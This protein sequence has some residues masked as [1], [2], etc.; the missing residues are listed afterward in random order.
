[1]VPIIMPDNHFGIGHKQ[2]TDIFKRK[3]ALRQRVLRS[4]GAFAIYHSIQNNKQ[5]KHTNQGFL[6][7]YMFRSGTHD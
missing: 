7:N 1:M 5:K 4:L 2:P 6:V 3:K